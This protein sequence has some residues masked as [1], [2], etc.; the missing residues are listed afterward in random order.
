VPAGAVCPDHPQ[1]YRKDLATGRSGAY[2]RAWARIARDW[3]EAFPYCEHCGRPAVVVDHV[4][5]LV[6]GGHTEPTNLQ[7]LCSSCH[8]AKTEEDLR[9]RRG[10]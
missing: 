10:R 4:A 6:D 3:L 2:S 7:G 8:R 5:P 1:L 9:A